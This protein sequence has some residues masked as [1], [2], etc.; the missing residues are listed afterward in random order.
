MSALLSS[1]GNSQ[2]AIFE[3]MQD[4][5]ISHMFVAAN[6]KILIGILPLVFFD[7][8]NCKIVSSTFLDEMLSPV[9]NTVFYFYYT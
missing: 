6:C 8:S 1:Y 5:N 3:F 7:L 9:W 2:F 4:V